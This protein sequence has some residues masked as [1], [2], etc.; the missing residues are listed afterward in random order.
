MCPDTPVT[1]EK[2]LNEGTGISSSFT[3]CYVYFWRAACLETENTCQ[4]LDNTGLR[5][6][7]VSE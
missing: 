4:V 2:I 5:N 3:N 7:E 1:N 6:T